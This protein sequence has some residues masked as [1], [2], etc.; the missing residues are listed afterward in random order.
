MKKI[1]L[2]LTLLSTT[3]FAEV[4]P[5]GTI[6]PLLTGTPDE[7][8]Q[9]LRVEI[10]SVAQT[11]LV[12][13]TIKKG[14]PNG[15]DLLLVGNYIVVARQSYP[16]HEAANGVVEKATLELSLVPATTKFEDRYELLNSF[17]YQAPQKLLKIK[18]VAKSLE[19]ES[20]DGPFS[21]RDAV[22]ISEDEALGKFKVSELEGV[23]HTE[24]VQ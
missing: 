2:S 20:L 12:G 13:V 10:F 15:F 21:L 11:P 4:K 8:S 23:V 7:S 22:L 14:A 9:V 17:S 1:L 19:T 3:L 18:A 5:E 16:K 6:L 24:G